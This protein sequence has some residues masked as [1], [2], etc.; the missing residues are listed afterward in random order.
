MDT[1]SNQNNNNNNMGW[2]G[3]FKHVGGQ[4]KTFRRLCRIDLQCKFETVISQLLL[5]LTWLQEATM[6]CSKIIW[7]R[8][9]LSRPSSRAVIFNWGSFA[10]RETFGSIWRHFD[11]HCV[12]GEC[13]WH[14]VGGGILLSILPCTGQSLQQRIVQ[15]KMSILLR[16]RKPEIESHSFSNTFP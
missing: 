13:Y 5:L 6:R 1:K 14:L 12:W 9:S 15:L 4:E 3:L 7:C 2:V 8:L 11:F 10:T 16:L